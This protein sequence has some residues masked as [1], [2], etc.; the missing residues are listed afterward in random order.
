F[1]CD[2]RQ[3]NVT[4]DFLLNAIRISQN[5]NEICGKL[6]ETVFSTLNPM[7]KNAIS[8]L[9]FM[10]IPPQT[11]SEDEVL[12]MPNTKYSFLVFRYS[13]RL[14]SN[15][16]MSA[17]PDIILLPLTVV[18]LYKYVVDKIGEIDKKQKLDKAI[19]DL[20]E[21]H[22]SVDC[23]SLEGLHKLPLEI[24]QMNNVR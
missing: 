13:G 15:F 20:L 24:I 10:G 11:Y 12:P 8:K 9:Y 22:S 23:R 5:P 17:G 4:R 3:V 19:I 14:T 16:H 1:I 2:Q 21:A 18:I 7:E 6:Y